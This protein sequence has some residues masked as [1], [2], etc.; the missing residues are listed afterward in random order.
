MNRRPSLP[1]AAALA[2]LGG[3]SLF[4]WSGYRDPAAAPTGTWSA[5]ELV[6]STAPAPAPP[7]ALPLPEDIPPTLYYADLG[8]DTIDVSDYPAQQKYNYNF[9][10]VHCARC[11]TLARAVNSPVKSRAYWHFHLIRMSLRSRLKNEG[12]IPKEHVKALLDF[13]E[14]DARV[15]KVED[16]KRFE[17]QTGELQRR[18]EPTLNRLL[19]HMQTSPQPTLLAPEGRPP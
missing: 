19:E 14:Y 2:L 13:L 10:R 1:F 18:F 4:R 9:F 3:C 17:A 16:R 12:P 8:L 6:L 15:R 11:H 5:A 7:P